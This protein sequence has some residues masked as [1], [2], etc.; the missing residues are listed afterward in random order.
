MSIAYPSL[1]LLPPPRHLGTFQLPQWNSS[2][3]L[4][5]YQA[6]NSLEI[7]ISRIAI[8]GSALLNVQSAIFEYVS[9]LSMSCWSNRSWFPSPSLFQ[10]SDFGVPLPLHGILPEWPLQSEYSFLHSLLRLIF[11][12]SY[13]LRVLKSFPFFSS[14]R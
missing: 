3:S 13:S 4:V 10:L 6:G 1:Y 7:W 14:N 12:I 8:T 2:E 9:A 5:L 11:A